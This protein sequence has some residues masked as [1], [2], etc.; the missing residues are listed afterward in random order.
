MTAN[1]NENASRFVPPDPEHP[2]EAQRLAYGD[3]AFLYLRSD[4]HRKVP[5]HLAR[6]N[7]QPPIDLGFS[8][9]FHIEG[10][11]RFGVTWAFLGE[12][13]EAKMMRGEALA[14]ADWRSGPNMWVIEIIAPY[15]QGTAASVVRWLRHNLPDRINTVKYLRIDPEVGVK[16]VIE[17]NRVKGAH[18]GAHRLQDPAGG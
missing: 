2:T 15:G 14:P 18:W 16:R 7:I 4:F 12:E 17:V 3:F 11:P 6:L 10:V 13:A 5:L 8:K 1:G 9:L